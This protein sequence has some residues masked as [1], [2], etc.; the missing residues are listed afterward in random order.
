[1]GLDHRGSSFGGLGLPPQPTTEHYENLLAESLD[2]YR[3]EGA[4]AIWL[5]AESIQVGCCRI[6]ADLFRQMQEA[7]V[8]EIQ[9]SPHERVQQL[10]GVYGQQGQ[11]ALAEA[12]SRISRRL[13]PQRTAQ[14]L[15]AI[16]DQ[17]WATAC[18]AMLDYYDRCYDREL[19]RSPKR[20]SL[21]VSGLNA[22]QAAERLLDLGLA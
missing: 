13:G 2:R 7:P 19:K 16:A 6:P 22:D 11:Q 5:E 17:D 15:E 3:L 12:T 18:E 21:D 9:R 14:A 10:V 20:R 4:T 8:L 1:M